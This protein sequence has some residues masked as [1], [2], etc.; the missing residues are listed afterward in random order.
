MPLKKGKSD[1]IIKANIVESIKSG[2][3]RNQ[4]IAIALSTA[5][6]KKT[7]KKKASKRKP[8]EAFMKPMT[9]SKELAAVVA[10]KAIPRTQVIKKIWDYIKKNN[11]QNPKNKSY[12][13]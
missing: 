8:N 9:P 3:P 7:A 6:K 4:A 1:K 2:K 13:S 5:G 10:E 11:L 12:A